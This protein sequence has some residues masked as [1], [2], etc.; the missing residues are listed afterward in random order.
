M[1]QPATISP[2]IE[3]LMSHGVSALHDFFPVGVIPL[4]SGVSM[5]APCGAVMWTEPQQWETRRFVALRH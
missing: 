4:K 3:L 1:Y 5:C 2:S